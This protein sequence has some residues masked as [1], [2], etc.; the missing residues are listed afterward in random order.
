MIPEI[1]YARCSDVHIAYQTVGSGPLDLVLVPGWVSNI[2]I[3]WEEPALVRFLQRL[4]SFSRLILFDKRGTGLSDRVCYTPTLEERMEDVRS[5]MDAVHS[6]RAALVGY[7][8]GGPMCCLFAATY[9]QRTSSLIMIGSYARRIKTPDYP[10]GASRE[11]FDAFLKQIEENWGDAVGLESRAPSMAG[12]TIFKQWW[13]RF[14]RLSASPATAIALTRMNSEIDVRKILPTIRV[15]TLVI[16]AEGDTVTSVNEG[17]YI[18][19]VIPDARF[20][21]IPSRDHLPWIGCPDM[22]LD[23]IEAFVTGSL[24]TSDINRVLYTVMFTDIADSTEI[25]S[26]VGDRQWQNILEAHHRAVRHEVAVY[27]GREIDSA[28]DGFFIAFDGPAR[29]IRCAVDIHKAVQKIQLT[30]R[31]GI[32]VGECEVIGDKLAGLAVHIGARISRKAVPG[33]IVVSQTVKD[34]VAGSGIEFKDQGAHILKGVPDKWHL[35][36]VVE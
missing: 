24:S 13:A 2:E 28:G 19:E 5:V 9:P 21:E 26:R 23:K 33:H 1:K 8:E 7:S 34:L 6:R 22:I 20:E 35:Y 10:W 16:H 17:R 14:L 12:D 27:A 15:P 29:A 31:I 25:A 36:Q 3:F 4:S 30:L 18:S 32:H 11:K